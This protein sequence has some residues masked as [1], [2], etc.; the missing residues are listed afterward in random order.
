M[1]VEALCDVGTPIL[2][3]NNLAQI[4]L[5]KLKWLVTDVTA[6]ESSDRVERAILR[7]ILAGQFF[8]QFRPCL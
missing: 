2:S 3:H 6:V 8:G 1:V 4:H 5:M 7:V